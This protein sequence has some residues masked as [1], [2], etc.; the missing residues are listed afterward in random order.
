MKT[1]SPI[2]ACSWPF[3]ARL[4]L[5]LLAMWLTSQAGFAAVLVSL[6]STQLPIGPLNTWTNTGATPGDFTSAGSTAPAIVKAK[7]AKGKK[8]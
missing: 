3:H 6:D 2:T 1:S 7:A 4:S 5:A 8:K